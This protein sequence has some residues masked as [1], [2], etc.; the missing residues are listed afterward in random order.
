M[1]AHKVCFKSLDSVGLLTQDFRGLM[2]ECGGRSEK[3]EKLSAKE[4]EPKGVK[5]L[6][7]Y[8]TDL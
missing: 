8:K 7:G 1:E 5:S 6:V 2:L 3:R 4:D